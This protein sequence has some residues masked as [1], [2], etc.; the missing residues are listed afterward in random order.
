M[1]INN[2]DF[3]TVDKSFPKKSSVATGRKDNQRSV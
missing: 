1:G 3:L 2:P